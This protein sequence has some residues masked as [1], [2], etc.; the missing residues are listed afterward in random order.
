ME[1]MPLSWLRHAATSASPD[2]PLAKAGLL[3]FRPRRQGVLQEVL[4]STHER[5]GSVA[6][7]I[8]RTLDALQAGY[9]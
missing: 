2:K 5:D 7:V 8:F 9:N 1:T 3:P 6:S 4:L